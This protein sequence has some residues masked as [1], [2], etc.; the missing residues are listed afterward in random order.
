VRFCWISVKPSGGASQATAPIHRHYRQCFKA[1]LNTFHV[2]L[3]P[4]FLGA[5]FPKRLAPG[6]RPVQEQP[7]Q[8]ATLFVRRDRGS[9]VRDRIG[10]MFPIESE[11][12]VCLPG[13]LPVTSQERGAAREG[14]GSG[15]IASYSVAIPAAMCRQ[16]IL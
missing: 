8:T 15:T 10:Q 3:A 2:Q 5:Q 1:F 11:P 16:H 9:R 6:A 12:Y 4:I 14:L 13:L 7:P